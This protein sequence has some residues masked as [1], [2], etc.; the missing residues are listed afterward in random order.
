MAK[1]KHHL[2]SQL[3]NEG[4]EFTALWNKG[5]KNGLQNKL[6]IHFKL[7]I[8]TVD[9][10]RRK[11]GLLSI[12]NPDHPGKLAIKKRMKRMYL[13]EGRSTLQIA[14][15]FWMSSQ[16]V[17]IYLRQ[18]GVTLGPQ[19][20]TN[21]KYFVTRS[22]ITPHQLLHKIKFMY[23]DQEMNAKTIAK[24]LH[25]DQGTVS[26]KL[27]AMGIK[28][29]RRFRTT[30]RISILPNLNIISIYKG[31]DIYKT[32]PVPTTNYSV[33]PKRHIKKGKKATCCWCR[34]KYHRYISKGI[35]K[36]KYC[37]SSCKN[38]A[39]DLRRMLKDKSSYK[40]RLDK[41]NSELQTT[42]GSQFAEVYKKILY[43]SELLGVKK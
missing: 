41:F 23:E 34:K 27:K 5:Y 14:K 35:R 30:E 13:R 18:M 8:S 3:S 36:Q 24:K 4:K 12:N 20:C 22:G 6:A 31:A 39:K 32:Y 10:I 17:N 7:S 15:I 25:I 28:I 21:P 40:F 26:T 42:W 16:G 11:L 19:H 2:F 29:V 33:N 37:C 1:S 43:S 38:K 9:R